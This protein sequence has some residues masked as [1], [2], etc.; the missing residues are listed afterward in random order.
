MSRKNFDSVW[1]ARE[2]RVLTMMWRD[3][4]DTDLIAERLSRRVDEILLRAK[5][6]GLAARNRLAR[7]GSR[8]RG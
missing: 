6:L 3:G 4:F 7:T 8:G 5:A 2:D 1:I